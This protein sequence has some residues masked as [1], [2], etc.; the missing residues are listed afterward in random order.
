M[1]PVKFFLYVRKSSELEESTGLVFYFP[2][3]TV[4]G[5]FL[6]T[7]LISV[8]GAIFAVRRINRLEPAAVFRA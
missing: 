4:L 7:L 2:W 1:K 5:I 8:G 6:V 3:Y